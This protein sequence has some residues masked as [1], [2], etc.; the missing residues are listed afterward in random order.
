MGPKTGRKR[1]RKTGGFQA[2]KSLCFQDE[3]RGQNGARLREG[4]PE[5]GRGPNYPHFGG[6]WRSHDDPKWGGGDRNYDPPSVGVLRTTDEEVGRVITTT[7]LPGLPPKGD[8][9]THDLPIVTS[10]RRQ[11]SAEGGCFD[12]SFLKDSDRKDNYGPKALLFGS[13]FQKE[14]IGGRRPTSRRLNSSCEARFGEA[15]PR[16]GAWAKPRTTRRA[17]EGGFAKQNGPPKEN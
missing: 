7:Q 10:C 12:E 15:K 13:F 14:L 1:G 4:V 6:K 9:I 5:G 3:K 11:N 8:L 17:A 2:L 16:R